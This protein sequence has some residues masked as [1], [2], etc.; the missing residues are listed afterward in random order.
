MLM[1]M[2][3]S[4]SEIEALKKKKKTP[5]KHKENARSKDTTTIKKPWKQSDNEL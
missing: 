4:E 1:K 3:F 5:L 2:K